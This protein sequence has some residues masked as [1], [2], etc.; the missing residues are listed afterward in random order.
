[1]K[2]F[3]S[4]LNVDILDFDNQVNE[5]LRKKWKLLRS[6]TLIRTFG[7]EYNFYHWAHLV[8]EEGEAK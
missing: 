7:P 8:K 4:L 6:G 5:L 3:V 1:M 2:K